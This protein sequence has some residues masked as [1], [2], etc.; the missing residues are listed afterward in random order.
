VTTFAAELDL[1]SL[2][3]LQWAPVWMTRAERLTLFALAFGLRPRRYLEIGT[4]RGGSALVVAAAMAAAGHAGRLVLLDPEPQIAPEHWER[5][6]GR[7]TLLRARSP[8]AL[9]QA[10]EA[11]GGPF[12]LALI[13][14]DHTCAG[15]LRDAE[16]LL[17]YLA[18]GAYVLFHD[19]FYSEIAQA[20]RAFAERH[21]DRVTDCGLL[22][23]EVTVHAE[24]GNQVRWGGLRLMRIRTI[25]S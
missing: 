10:Q 19:G 3:V 5:L 9:P 14:G 25:Q 13:D 23:R 11:A 15:V 20:L 24:G 1:A 17:P 8:E 7:A 2:E 21:P 6:A 16:G 4:L 12:D 22:T 18:D